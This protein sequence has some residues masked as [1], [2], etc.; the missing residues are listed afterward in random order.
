M[1]RDDDFIRAFIVPRLDQLEAEFKLLR[2][3]TWPVCQSLKEK[4][5]PLS[6]ASEKRKYFKF[7]FKDEALSLINKKAE[8]SGITDKVIMDQELD[9][10]CV[11]SE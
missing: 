9:S 5:N 2:E 4:G 11:V 1:N 6:F 8:F 7:L 10:I 3:V